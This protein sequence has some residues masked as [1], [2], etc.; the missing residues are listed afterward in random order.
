MYLK[1][2]GI[3]VSDA[4]KVIE[5]D[6]SLIPNRINESIDI[7]SRHGEIYNGFKYGLRKIKITFDINCPK[8]EYD[9]NVNILVSALDVTVPQRLYL[10]S[11]DKYYYAIQDG[12]VELKNIIPGLSNGSINF[13][14]YDP[15]AYS[16]K[17]NIFEGKNDIVAKNNGTTDSYPL[18]KANFSAESHFVQVTNAYNGKAILV[19]EWPD[20]SKSSQSLAGNKLNDDCKVTTNWLSAGNVVDS[21]RLVEGGITINSGGYGIKASNFGTNKDQKWHGPCVRRNIGTNIKDFEVVAT[22]EHDSKGKNA[23]DIANT[24]P[25]TEY[26][27]TY[28]LNIRNGRGTSHSI[29]TTIPKGTKLQ[30]TDIAEGWGRTSYKG[31]DGYSS[32]QYLTLVSSSNTTHKVNTRSSKGLN[33]RTGAGTGYKIVLSIPNGTSITVKDITN[34]WGKTTYKNSTGYVTMEYVEANK[35]KST[36]YE[37]IEE[38]T[39]DDKLGII[40]LYGFDSN[41]QKLF[42]FMLADSNEWYE[43][44]YPQI[45]IGNNIVLQESANAP[46]PRTK[47]EKDDKGEDVTTTEL[48]GK[49]GKWN[50]FFGNLR[51][52]REKNQWTCEV[53]KLKNNTVAE[54]IKT[55]TLASDSY[56]K[57]DLNHLILYLG[58][59]QDKPQVSMA[60]TSVIVNQLNTIPP[61]V[62]QKI[63]KRGDE[64][65]IDCSTNMVYLNSEPY[66]QHLD[67]GSQFFELKPGDTNIKVHSDDAGIFSTATVTERW[68]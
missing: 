29:L 30:V 8:E 5:I 22:F 45:Q 38:E 31:K 59:Y 40:E 46:A 50:E 25:S 12:Q 64:L 58:V 61:T 67:I 15:M 13:I 51:I 42:K 18:I 32:M 62:N 26:M 60:L 34:G 47:T 35:S 2:A 39:A 52:K 65:E 56:P 4:I 36:N 1:Y 16:D 21:D 9:E 6:N 53:N 23:S 11:K 54:S 48:S 28:N 19:G 20:I 66:M 55:T 44:S 33:M 68:L 7:P 3:M 57:G 37:V 63:F 27:T 49:F 14:C 24:P 43:Y 41:G 10:D 17:Y